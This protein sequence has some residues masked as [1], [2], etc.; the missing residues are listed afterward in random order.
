MT[1]FEKRF[2]W[3]LLRQRRCGG[4]DRLEIAE[5]AHEISRGLLA[6]SLHAG[7]VVGTVADEG[8]IVRDAIRFD[9]ETLRAVLHRHPLFLDA[10]RTTASWVQ[11]PDTR[12]DELLKVL[13][14][15]DDHDVRALRDA[16]PS[17][18]ADDVVR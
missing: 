11:E 16:L 3:T 13:V 18:R 15:R 2:T 8:E 1:L 12:A 17:K 5:L 7:H 4:E 9:A 10:G 6:D 14:A